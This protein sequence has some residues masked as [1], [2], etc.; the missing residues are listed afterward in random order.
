MNLLTKE[1]REILEVLRSHWPEP[2]NIEDISPAAFENLQDFG[3]VHYEH[4]TGICRITGTGM[5]WARA[6]HPDPGPLPREF[7]TGFH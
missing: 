2:L 4:Q 3:L 6:N 7:W 5:Q 1:S